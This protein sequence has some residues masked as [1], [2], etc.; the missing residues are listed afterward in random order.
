[1]TERFE[2]GRI[3]NTQGL[4]GE[5]RVLPSTDD[6]ARFS[7]IKTASVSLNGAALNLPVESVWHRPPFVIVKFAGY[8]DATAADKLRGGVIGVNRSE[9]IPLGKDEYYVPDLIGLAVRTADGEPLGAITDVITT[10]ANDVYE[11][12]NAETGGRVLIPAI[13]QCVLNVDISRGVTVSL[14][15]G[16]R[17]L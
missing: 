2:I 7:L 9:A 3:V 5:V 8:D 1:M 14:L 15:P 13:K 17:E 11:V 10:G 12:T 6:P 4:K 16:L